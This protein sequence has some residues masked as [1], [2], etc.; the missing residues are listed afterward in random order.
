VSGGNLEL[1]RRG[2]EA[3]NRGDIDSVLALFDADIEW[4]GYTHLPESGTLHGRDEVRAWLERFLYAWQEL[5]IELVDLRG[6]RDRVV[7]LVSFRALGKGSG[8][9]VEGG[10]DAHVWT[11]RDGKAVA[12]TLYQGTHDALEETAEKGNEETTKGGR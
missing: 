2:Y 1:I 8:V 11:I 5:D 7:A 6:A 10:V 9:Q 3:W 4:R 12:V